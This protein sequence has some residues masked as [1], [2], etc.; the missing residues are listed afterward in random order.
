MGTG[1]FPGV[2]RPG[3]GFNAPPSNGEFKERE[4][5]CLYYPLG[6]HGL[7]IGELHFKCTLQTSY[8]HAEFVADEP[9]NSTGFYRW[10]GP[11]LPDNS[12]GSAT[13]PGEDC[14]TMHTNGGL[15]D[16]ACNGKYPFIC[17]QELW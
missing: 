11:D 8:C 7:L 4:E 5:L 15:N 13:N 14:G 9:L 3:R 6:L 2:K 10:S 16:I 12:G 1:S 17:E